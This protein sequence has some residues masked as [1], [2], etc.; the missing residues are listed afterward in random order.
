EDRLRARGRVAARITGHVFKTFRQLLTRRRPAVN[1]QPV[2]EPLRLARGQCPVPERRNVR[3][4]QSLL[5]SAP[6]R[7]VIRG[8]GMIK[9]G[10][11]EYFLAKRTLDVTPGRALLF[12]LPIAQTVRVQVRL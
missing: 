9:D 3:V 12:G 1:Q 7:R 2:A 8:A 6:A 11:A 10:D 4:N 5:V